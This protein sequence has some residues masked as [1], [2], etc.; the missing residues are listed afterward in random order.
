MIHLIAL[1]C[2]VLF[3]NERIHAGRVAKILKS[4]N[5][6]FGHLSLLLDPCELS[7]SEPVFMKAFLS[8]V[9]THDGRGFLDQPRPVLS[10]HRSNDPSAFN[11][12]RKILC[13]GIAIHIAVKR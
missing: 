12:L 5:P 1:C 13:E 7:E 2:I 10:I 8:S 3:M 4:F 9:D 11:G 6:S